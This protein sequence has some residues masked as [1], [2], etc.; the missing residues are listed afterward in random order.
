VCA[1]AGFGKTTLLS[2]WATSASCPVAWLSLD[3]G[4]NDPAR[5]WRY[6]VAALDRARDGLGEQLL[7]LLT[8]LT[9]L[10]GQGVVNRPHQPAGGPARGARPVRGADQTEVSTALAGTDDLPDDRL[11]SDLSTREPEVSMRSCMDTPGRV[12]TRKS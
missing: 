1:P 6:V 11:H 5:S 2:D 4:D 10:S 3:E 9:P 8:A 12:S 7:P